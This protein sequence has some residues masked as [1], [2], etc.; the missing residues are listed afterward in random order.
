MGKI[1]D[2]NNCA[3]DTSVEALGTPNIVSPIAK[4][5][6]SG[7]ISFITDED[8]VLIDIAAVRI[9]D[10]CREKRPLPTLEC[11]GPR[12]KIYFDP[13][14]IRC[15]LVTCGGICPGL[16]AII[17]SVVLELFYGYGVRHIYG[18]RYGLQGFIAKYQHDVM[19][20]SPEVVTDI[21]KKGGTILGSSRGEQ[22]LDA[23]VDCLERLGIGALFMI[24]GDGT[25]VAATRITDTILSLSLI[26]ISEPTRP[27]RQSRIPSCA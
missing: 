19:E 23:I 10:A 1:M 8:R 21:M 18:I 24:G 9:A 13:S 14:K 17:R 6:P 7:Q 2:Q 20:L 22:D 5:A 27:R 16:N 12:Q 4:R 25:L 15:A 11:A 3:I 26:H